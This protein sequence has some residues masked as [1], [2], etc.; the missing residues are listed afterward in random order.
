[1]LHKL[2]DILLRYEELGSML[3]DPEITSDP[4]QLI[5][6][7]KEHSSLQD[8]VEA[9]NRHTEVEQELEDNKLLLSDDDPEMRDMARAEIQE[10]E[11]E[12]EDLIERIKWMLIPKDPLDEKNIFIEIRA[13][14]G[15]DESA[16]FA[17]EL[18]RMYSR[19][20]EKRGWR[21]HITSI[22][23]TELG[24]FR[25]IVAQIDGNDV[26]SR[27][28]YEAGTH[29]I[30][31][32]PKTESGGRIHTSTVTVAVM[33]E[34]DEVSLDL[35]VRDLDIST[36]RASGAGGQHVNKTD[37]AVRIVHKPSGTVVQCQNQRSQLKNKNS[38]MKELRARLF[39]IERALRHKSI[40]ANRRA[41]VGTGDRSERIRTYNEPQSR[42]TDHRI[43]L[44]LHKFSQVLNGD[45]DDLVEPL[46]MHHQTEALQDSDP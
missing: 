9:Y 13:A 16:L 26:Y 12:Q 21:V 14:A 44:T 37:S 22:S 23:E 20:A 34:V 4:K 15:G 19:Y 28:K 40:D 27:L 39:E 38:A 3:G 8:L 24:G 30:Q 42:I 11:T 35:D 29:R 7:S 36:Y 5:A 1:M 31:R 17:Q 43:G 33:P 2:Q 10:L 45:L 6:L 41:Q 25:D 18:F 32:I 46:I